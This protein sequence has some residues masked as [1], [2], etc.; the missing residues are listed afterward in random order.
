MDGEKAP[1]AAPP[2]ASEQSE[3]TLAFRARH[4]LRNIGALIASVAAVGAV[5]SGLVGYWNV[6]KTIKT[7]VLRQGAPSQATGLTIS[8]GPSVAVLPFVNGTG[9]PA[10]DLI[11][12]EMT[13]D[14]IAGLAKFKALRVASR[15]ETAKFRSNQ[16]SPGD[17]RAATGAD[18]VVEAALRP[19]DKSRLSAQV[20]DARTG[21]QFWTKTINEPPARDGASATEQ[22]SGFL[23]SS[24]GSNYGAIAYNEYQL[25]IS[26][27]VEDLAPYPCIIASV[28]SAGASQWNPEVSKRARTCI[29]RLLAKEP[30]NATAWSALAGVY[31]NE[32]YWGW[33]LPTDQQEHVDK[34]AYLKDKQIDAAAKAVE[35]DPND[36]YS[37]RQLAIAYLSSC[38]FSAGLIEAR[39]ALELNPYDPNTEAFVGNYLVYKGDLDVGVKM[40]EHALA[41]AG[42]GAPLWFW[43]AMAV[44]SFVLGKHDEAV[45]F[46]RKTYVE[47]FW[48]S[49]MLMAYYLESAGRRDEAQLHVAKLLKLKPGFTIREADGYH[50]MWCF[51]DSY[52]NPMK[53]ALKAA[54]LPE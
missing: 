16:S 28:A 29:D 37:R 19:G 43:N 10:K 17:V 36:S 52:R 23:A 24:I 50:R 3:K 53:A 42:S 44:R 45:D 2:Q 13:D 1:E 27:P 9:D 34:R 14:V 4:R 41:L 5:A 35:I 11:A 18:Y 49:H 20:T 31:F 46:I 47:Q 30:R 39:R 33:G 51:P 15:G 6:W 12:D 48:N 22:I 26:T 38:N 21:R 32:R 8:M 40:V 25:Q 7:D 54:G